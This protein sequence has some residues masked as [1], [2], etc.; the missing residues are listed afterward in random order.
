MS[1][2]ITTRLSIPTRMACAVV[3]LAAMMIVHPS[4]ATAETA[5][6]NAPTTSA[7]PVGAPATHT[8][9]IDTAAID[10]AVLKNMSIGQIPGTALV[11]IQDGQVAYQKGYGVSSL[12]NQTPTTAQILFQLGSTSKAFTGLG[13]L[14]CQQRGLLSMDA[15]V[16]TYL[17]W[18]VLKHQGKPVE[19]TLNQFMHHTSGVPD[20]TLYTIPE[21]AGPQMLEKTVRMI[22]GMELASA[23]GTQFAYTSMNY[24]VLGLVMQTVTQ[25]IYADFVSK[26][27]LEPL[28]LRNTTVFQ[29]VADDRGI[30][31]GFKIEFLRPNAYLA[32]PFDG[33]LPAG[34]YISDGIDVGRWLQIHLGTVSVPDYFK[35]LLAESII[36][37]SSSDPSY[38]AGWYVSASQGLIYHGGNNPNYSS[39]FIFSP[40]RNMAV[41]IIAN[42]NSNSTTAAAQDV[43]NI[44]LGRPPIFPDNNPTQRMDTLAVAAIGVESLLA[45]LALW[46]L[47]RLRGQH[48]YYQPS[49]Q[50]YAI[51]ALLL[52]VVAVIGYV[53]AHF[54]Q[55]FLFG[56]NWPFMVVWGP[57]TLWIAAIL[58]MIL[59]LLAWFDVVIRLFFPRHT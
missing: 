21:G 37:Y 32:P 53:L 36:P 43:V 11:I 38:A 15:P 50:A 16:T 51:S 19:V 35:P 8:S 17:P 57:Q 44:L 31:D 48:R 58:C 59:V 12:S 7:P 13:T 18:L 28:G 1:S 6:I 47:S 4:L 34:Y 27:I 25:T 56:S 49:P 24:D 2:P 22:A 46:S 23:P 29:K 54:P 10:A 20:S 55:L 40:P 3:S 45:I 30:S 26:E 39:Y 9:A 42:V 14:L 52:S 41:G 33:N 5:T